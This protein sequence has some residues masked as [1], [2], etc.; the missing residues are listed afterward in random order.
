MSRTYPLEGG[1]LDSFYTMEIQDP[2]LTSQ[3]LTKRANFAWEFPAPP[4][5]AVA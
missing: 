5:D 3:E 1:M 2:P 4:I